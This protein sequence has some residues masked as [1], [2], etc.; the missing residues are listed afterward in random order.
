MNKSFF[1]FLSVAVVVLFACS[2]LVSLRCLQEPPRYL[3]SGKSVGGS[4]FDAVDEEFSIVNRSLATAQLEDS[5]KELQS[6]RKEF[7]STLKSCLGA[8]CMT[9]IFDNAERIGFL[10]PDPTHFSFLS[11]TI[12][13]LNHLGKNI[14]AQRFA[15]Q[16][17]VPPY[18]YGRNHG[19]TKIIRFADNI[20]V[21]AY[22]ITQLQLQTQQQ[23]EDFGT[24]G[25]AN[26]E[27][28][29]RKVFE[30]HVSL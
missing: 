30:I 12:E 29:V 18:G 21:Q 26:N 7:D 14:D 4:S 8:Y 17:N 16:H 27:E 6:I 11:P 3:E 19:W 13:D 1:I 23:V 5:L 22:R 9:E 20:V 10:T 2:A 24:G 15:V 25:N 28:L